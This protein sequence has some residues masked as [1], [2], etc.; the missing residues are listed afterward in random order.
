MQRAEASGTAPLYGLRMIQ[1]M[2]TSDVLSHAE[3][4]LLVLNSP[5]AESLPRP[6]D[7]ECGHGC[8]AIAVDAG[9][10]PAGLGRSNGAR[11]RICGP[12]GD[13]RVLIRMP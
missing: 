1:A 5:W 4:S 8:P 3:V 10:R 2:P 9:H 7:R 11:N 6:L 13:E 12:T